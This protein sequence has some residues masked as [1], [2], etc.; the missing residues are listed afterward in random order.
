MALDDFDI[1]LPIGEGATAKVY[2][3]QH[4]RSRERYALKVAPKT[5]SSTAREQRVLH[6]ISQSCSSPFLLRLEASWHDSAHYYLLSRWCEGPDLATQLDLEGKFA[7][8][9]AKLY[10]AQ[11]I[12]ALENLHS[13]RI[14][15]RDVKPSNVFFDAEGNAVLGDLGLGKYVPLSRNP[16]EPDFVHFEADPN[17]TSGSFR[18]EECVTSERCGTPAFMSPDQYVGNQY[19]FD[20]DIWSLGMTFFFMLTGRSPFASNPGTFEECRQAALCEPV[21]FREEDDLDEEVR[22]VVLWCL[23]KNRRTRT[24]LAELKRHTFFSCVDWAEL[25]AGN[26]STPWQPSAPHV[27]RKGQSGLVV[28]GEVYEKGIDPL[29]RFT[30]VPSCFDRAPKPF[31]RLPSALGSPASRSGLPARRLHRPSTPQSPF[32]GAVSR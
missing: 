25:A 19:S 28:A 5:H 13:Q 10:L 20:T 14:I 24:T 3:V 15:H 27:P 2:L 11:L 29:P 32:P 9:R 21:V 12:I 22:D 4:K 8:E 7:R 18:W 6:S 26:V 17:A 30:F 1:L 23:S 31:P 16:E